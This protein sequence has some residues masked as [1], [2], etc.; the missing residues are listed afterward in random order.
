M[1]G[2]APNKK[3]FGNLLGN[4]DHL[5]HTHSLEHNAFSRGQ[6]EWGAVRANE[7]E[8][9]V[10]LHGA[11]NIAA[12]IVGNPWPVRPGCSYPQSATSNALGISAAKITS[13]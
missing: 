3:Q 13:C 7:L 9:L 5:P 10:A 4:V 8:E 12:V 6:P 1:G 2:M 11:D